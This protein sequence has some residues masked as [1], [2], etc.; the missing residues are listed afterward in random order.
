MFATLADVIDWYYVKIRVPMLYHKNIATF[1]ILHI[2]LILI[3]YSTYI[4]SISFLLDF[5]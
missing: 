5:V 3:L 2:I 1:I 4:D